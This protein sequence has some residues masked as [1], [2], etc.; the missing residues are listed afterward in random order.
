MKIYRQIFFQ[1]IFYSAG[2]G[3]LIFSAL[4]AL[5]PGAVLAYFNLNYLL[6]FWLLIG[7]IILYDKQEKK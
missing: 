4:E 3:I 2:A 6:L 5:W 7:I 1:E